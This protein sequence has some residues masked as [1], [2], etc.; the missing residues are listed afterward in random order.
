MIL[1]KAGCV[2]VSQPQSATLGIVSSGAA[3]SVADPKGVHLGPLRVLQSVKPPN[4]RTNPF[5]ALH[6]ESLPADV[7][8]A[9]FSWRAALLQR[10]D[11]L[12]FQWPENLLRASHPVKRVLKRAA[13][14]ALLIRL[15]ITRTPIVIT[16][17]NLAPHESTSVFERVLLR[18]AHTS[19][20][21][22]IALN[23]TEDLKQFG[24]ARVFVIPHGDYRQRYQRRD[25][26]QAICGRVLFFGTIRAYKNVPTLIQATKNCEGA[27]LVVAGKPLAEDARSAIKAEAK[28]HAN[29]RLRLEDVP[30][31][32]L[33]EEIAAAELVALPYTSLY[34]SGAIFLALTIGVPVLAPSTASTRQLQQEVGSDWL[35]LY[36]DAIDSQTIA[37]ALQH[38]RQTRNAGGQPRLDRRD[39]T[40]IGEAY[41]EAYSAVTHRR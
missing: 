38:A 30:E 13:F 1:A 25:A 36:D 23:D 32:E 33:V 18:R 6:V 22:F 5:V 34:N 10:Y 7:R 9:W 29:V 37:V 19:A 27:S 28:S 31:A 24:D 15:W 40:I 14:S 4:D 2:R 17:H 11:V 8:S 20:S 16:I 21:G 12:H 3:R 35:L 26:S 41:A 39:W